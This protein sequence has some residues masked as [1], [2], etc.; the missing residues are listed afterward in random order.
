MPRDWS[1][2]NQ[3]DLARFINAETADLIRLDVNR[4]DLVK[5]KEGRLQLVEAIY[6]TLIQ[7]NINYSLEPFNPLQEGIQLIR[8]PIE[9]LANQGQGTC[10]DLAVLFCSLCLGYELL[11]YI[12]IINGHALAAVSLD[13]DLRN[14]EASTRRKERILF[15]NGQP[16]TDADKL[17]QLIDSGSYVAVECTGFARSTSQ[18][19]SSSYP[20]GIERTTDGLLS[21]ERACK[22]GREQLNTDRKLI[23]ALDLAIAHYEWKIKPYP[24][25]ENEENERIYPQIGIEPPIGKY[26]KIVSKTTGKAISVSTARTENAASLIQWDWKSGDEQKFQLFR[27]EGEKEYFFQA[28]HSC[29]CIGVKESSLDNNASVIQYECNHRSEQKFSLI[30]SG[31]YYKIKAKHSGKVLTVNPS[32]EEV[33]QYDDKD[34]EG[35]HFTLI[36]LD[37]F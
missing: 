23:F 13:F 21:F 18:T 27:I 19:L 34:F 16:L 17:R 31:R 4:A 1:K 14:Y 29:K 30:P 15:Q 20:E 8:T 24:L 11:P 36:M 7:K 28:K 10:L 12:I 32:K 33:V 25:I 35:Q 3:L 37:E 26:Y 5:T 2:T 9:I 6:N 22:A